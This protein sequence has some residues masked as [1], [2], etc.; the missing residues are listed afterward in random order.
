[1]TFIDPKRDAVAAYRS[2]MAPLTCEFAALRPYGGATL[3]MADPPWFFENRSQKGEAKNPNQHYP[4]MPTPEIAAMPVEALA[5][6]NCVLWLWATNPMLPDALFV[7]DSW[8]FKYSTAGTW[9]KRTK[10]GKLAFGGGYALRSASE[11]YL[12]GIRGHMQKDRARNV[13][14]VI[15]AQ[16]REHSRKPDEAYHAAREIAPSGPAF[17]LF[18]RQTREGWTAWGNETGKFD[19]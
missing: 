16:V 17:D 3:I 1:M 18:S 7:L 6:D 10:N 2:K 5:G 11:P 4:C 12:I 15:E 19:G 14:T 13:R 9:V 8:G